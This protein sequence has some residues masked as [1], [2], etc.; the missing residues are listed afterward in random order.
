[1]E[2]F[3]SVEQTTVVVFFIGLLSTHF[4]MKV[5]IRKA[6]QKNFIVQDMYKHDKNDVPTMGGLVVIAGL[7]LAII[8]AQVLRGDIDNL[9]L[10]YFI[11]LTFGLYG[12]TDDLFA[13]KKRYDKIPILFLLA[14]PI[15][16]ITTDTDLNLIFTHLETGNIIYA[17]VFAPIYIMVVA[18]MVNIHAGYN[19]LDA[20]LSLILLVTIGIKTYLL[21]SVSDLI[22]IAPIIG[23]LFAFMW[24]NFP[25]AKVLP[26][27]VGS[28]LFGGALGSL[29]VLKNIN[30]FGIIILIPHILNF[31]MDTYTLKIRKLPLIRFG[32]LRED[33]TI[34]IPPSM[35]YLSMKFFVSSC[36]NMT[37]KQAVIV[38]YAI[39]SF[40]C[41][42]GLLLT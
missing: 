9:M 12:L 20:G 5:F 27:N 6:V 34:C 29:L 3:L 31:L 35:K 17:L 25:P 14:I 30:I 1:M 2:S 18:N 4:L 37:E 39:T 11:V 7:A 24:Y 28:F 13:F 33:K 22:Y 38:Q 16:S 23:A 10:F 41:I 32:E 21:G 40:F 42:L 36:F 15:G 19:G 8:S 26:G